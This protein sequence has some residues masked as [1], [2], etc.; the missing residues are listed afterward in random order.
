MPQHQI[1]K[2][3]LISSSRKTMPPPL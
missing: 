2:I 1:Q 3:P